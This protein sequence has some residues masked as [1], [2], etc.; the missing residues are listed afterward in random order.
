MIIGIADAFCRHGTPQAE[1]QFPPLLPR[2]VD[3][4]IAWWRSLYADADAAVEVHGRDIVVIID[5]P[6]TGRKIT[7][8]ESLLLRKET[9]HRA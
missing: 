6:V 2:S 4:R 1:C 3:E 5:L 7:V 9:I 8:M